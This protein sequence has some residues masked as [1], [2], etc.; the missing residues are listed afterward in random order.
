MSNSETKPVRYCQFGK[1]VLDG[2]GWIA[3]VTNNRLGDALNIEFVH[4]HLFFIE[5]DKVLRNI[6]YGE[7]SKRFSEEDYG[8]S[9]QTLDDLEKN[10]YW[11]VG[12]P[13]HPEAATE[14]LEAQEDGHYYSFFSNQ[15]QDWADRLRR[16]IEKVE[17]LRVLPALGKDIRADADA[18]FWEEKPPTVPGSLWLALVA[19]LLGLGSFLAPA[20]AAERSVMVLAAFLIISGIAEIAYAFHS[21][22]WRQFLSTCLFALLN[23]ATGVALFLETSLVANWVGGIFA[24]ALAIN[25]SIRIAVALGSRPRQR[26]LV[27]LL[28]GLVLLVSAVLL[29]TRTVGQRDVAFGM[30]IGFNL[31]LGGASTLWLRWMAAREDEKLVAS[32]QTHA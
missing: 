28:A 14:A 5:G 31:L 1:R 18:R 11:L 3:P 22:V 32:D 19:I 6:G 9:L 15:C 13:Y 7:K 12:R 20:V 8:K 25:G 26:W 4:Q 24:L 23:I 17:K 10:G 21:H 27:S 2:F 30:I 16:R 29:F